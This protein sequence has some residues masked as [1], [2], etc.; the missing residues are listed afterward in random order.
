[1]IG[2]ASTKNGVGR[3]MLGKAA[4]YVVDVVALTISSSNCYR[5]R[6]VDLG[7]STP[8]R[9]HYHLSTTKQQ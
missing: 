5:S 8:K 1:M 7:G 4:K 3:G 6:A 9:L 2:L